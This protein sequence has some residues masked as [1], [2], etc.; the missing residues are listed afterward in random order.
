MGTPQDRDRPWIFAVI[1]VEIDY[2]APGR[3]H[4]A[5]VVRTGFEGMKGP[6][7]NFQ[8][9]VERRGEVLAEAVVVAVPFTPMDAHGALP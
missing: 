3:I 2:K 8:Q 1:R 9:T 5:L 4:D 7:L 6:R